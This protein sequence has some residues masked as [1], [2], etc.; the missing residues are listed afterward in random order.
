MSHTA[1]WLD[2][3]EA[4]VFHVLSETFDET[5]VK[6][7]QH[8]VHRHTKDPGAKTH[9]HPE[10]EQHFF[11]EVCKHISESRS[12]LVV[13]PSIAKLHFLRYLHV[14]AAAIEARVVGIETVDHPTDKQMVAYVRAYFDMPAKD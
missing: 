5:T 11:R 13:G 3:S 9:S 2:S 14:H 4:N 10:D 12:I 1:V 6:A 8:R 7:P